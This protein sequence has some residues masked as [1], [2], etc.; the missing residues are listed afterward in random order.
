MFEPKVP[1]T[2][3]AETAAAQSTEWPWHYPWAQ[4]AD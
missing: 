2:C 1:C 3:G 4:G